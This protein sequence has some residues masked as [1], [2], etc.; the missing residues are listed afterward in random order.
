M[1]YHFA[2]HIFFLYNLTRLAQGLYV[3]SQNNLLSP[4]VYGTAQKDDAKH[5]QIKW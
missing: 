4:L 2:N 5:V 1:H 3:I